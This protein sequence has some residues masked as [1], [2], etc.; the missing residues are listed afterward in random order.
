MSVEKIAGIV[1]GLQARLEDLKDH[2]TEDVEGEYRKALEEI[3]WLLDELEATQGDL[4]DRTDDLARSY[5]ELSVA[6]EALNSSAAGIV[7]TGAKGRIAYTNPAFLQMFEYGSKEEVLGR[8]AAHLF[9]EEKIRSLSDVEDS[10]DGGAGETEEFVA[11]RKDGSKMDVE[12]SSSV[13]SDHQ[14]RP[15]GRMVSFVDVTERK[16]AE[17]A[18]RDTRILLEKVFESLEEV[19][20]VVDVSTRTIVSCNCAVDRVFGYTADEVIGRNTEFLHVDRESYEEFGRRL[21]STLDAGGVFRAEYRMKR[22][23]GTLFHSEHIVT[24]ILD[25]SGKHTE[26]VSVVRDISDRKL[27]E[28]ELRKSGT[29]LA[30]AQ[31]IA[32][33]GN[34]VWDIAGEGL[35]WSDEV[36]RIFGLA[37]REFRATYDAFIG[38]VHPDDRLK[39]Q[40][41]VDRAVSAREPYNIQHRIV[42]PDGAVRVVHEQGVVSY[43]PEGK[44]VRMLGTVLD[45]TDLIRAREER[46]QLF[47]A[48]ESAADAMVVTDGRGVILYANPAFEDVTGYPPG[49][50]V[51]QDLHVLDTSEH[52]PDFNQE[53]RRALEKD[54]VWRGRLVNYKKDGTLYHED[55]TVTAVKDA[56][57]EVANYVAVKRDVTETLRLES[58]SEAVNVADNIGYVFSGIRHEI[59]NPVHAIRMTLT[60]L[61]SRLEKAGDTGS[62]KYIQRGLDEINRVQYL[63]DNLKSF[64]LFENPTI[65]EVDLTRFLEKFVSLLRPDLDKKGVSLEVTI[66]P[67]ASVCLAD[68]RALQQVMLNIVT[69][70]VEACEDREKP[71]VAIRVGKDSGE[72]CIRVRD[73]GSG[74]TAEQL[75]KLFRPF[76]TTKP[77]G[78]GLGLVIARRMLLKMNGSVEIESEKERGTTARICLPPA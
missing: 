43:G 5:R 16:S 39:V 23:D 14:D 41:A 15:A 36:Y 48:V 27:A 13:V 31:R 11:R 66:D 12:V 4:V 64:N 74:M 10:I 50:V 32:K 38:M 17:R 61:K 6:Y 1:G 19:V 58:L 53:L 73:N 47:T 7:I 18:L 45:I 22:K 56:A 21:F 54:G 24:E 33:L 62:G 42:R 9:A 8:P 46:E 28:E 68:T 76:Q 70:A 69:N 2:V 65:R 49:E 52:D 3:T 55:C 67:E 44:A 37:P 59:G 20:F 34:W 60:M 26:V 71:K 75:E 30:E 51:G 78:T 35:N 63:L 25:E 29:R 77:K 72:V 40:T 57:G